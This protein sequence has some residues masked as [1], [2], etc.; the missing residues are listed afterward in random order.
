MNAIHSLPML[1]RSAQSRDGLT[2]GS[3]REGE[4]RLWRH[5]DRA[6]APELDA[7][8]DVRTLSARP[9]FATARELALARRRDPNLPGAGEVGKYD[10]RFPHAQEPR[11]DDRLRFADPSSTAL[12]RR[13]RSDLCREHDPGAGGLLLLL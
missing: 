2:S 1:R 10:H 8:A 13:Q 7:G 6:D 4:V 12:T 5:S 11:S 3:W 9:A